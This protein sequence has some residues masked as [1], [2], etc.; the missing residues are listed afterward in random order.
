MLIPI[1][2]CAIDRESVDFRGV[3]LISMLLSVANSHCMAGWH[4]CSSQ[5]TTPFANPFVPHIYHIFVHASIKF[6]G[7]RSCD[8]E[9][10][11]VA[12]LAAPA[13]PTAM[14]PQFAVLFPGQSM[15]KITC[16]FSIMY[17]ISP[18]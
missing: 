1:A 16:P 8:A 15:L 5:S 13:V 6:H 17:F 4:A 18:Q 9:D 3:L 12:A 2:I 14:H 11:D 10:I 7:Q